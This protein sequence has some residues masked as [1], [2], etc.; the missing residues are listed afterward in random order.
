MVP[1][2]GTPVRAHRLRPLNQPR[3]VVVELN[4]RELPVAVTSVG[5]DVEAIG[6]IFNVFNSINPSGF[7]ARVIVPSSGISDATL[8]QP[9]S[10]SGDFRRP[11]QRVGQ[12]G[13]RFTF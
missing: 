3:P 11:E 2:T 6:E 10:F 12:I 1:N 13:L 5:R 7:R 4:E 9:T 8:L